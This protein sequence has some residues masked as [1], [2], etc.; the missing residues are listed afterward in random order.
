MYLICKVG[1]SLLLLFI[2][3]ALVDAVCDNILAELSSAQ[4]MQDKALFTGIDD[5]AVIKLLKLLGQLRLKSQFPQRFQYVIVHCLRRIV[6]LQAFCHR[7]AVL[8]NALRARFC[9]H[10][11]GEIHALRFFQLL[12][13]SQ[14]I[15]VFPISHSILSA[16]TLSDALKHL[17][18]RS[19]NRS[20]YIM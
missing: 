19:R 2:E 6:V 11:R 4:L 12:K 13:G 9:A 8:L 20:D 7:H 10:H 1:N 15:K 5:G 17:R 3:R 16:P 18:N 14:C